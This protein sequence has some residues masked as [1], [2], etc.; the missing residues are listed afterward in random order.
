MR[1]SLKYDFQNIIKKKEG[2]SVTAYWILRNEKHRKNYNY[3][4]NRLDGAQGK[5]KIY[6]E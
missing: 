3:I 6:L 1:T 4:G 2:W 5:H